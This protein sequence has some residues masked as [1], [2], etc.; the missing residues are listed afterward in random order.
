MR[1][2]LLWMKKF[3]SVLSRALEYLDSRN[4]RNWEN[5][6]DTFSE[7]ELELLMIFQVLRHNQQV[8][9]LAPA[10]Q[11]ILQQRPDLFP[12]LLMKGTWTRVRPELSIEGSVLKL[13]EESVAKNSDLDLPTRE[14]LLE[15][16]RG[17]LGF[18]L[19]LKRKRGSPPNRPESAIL[20]NHAKGAGGGWQP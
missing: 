10:E 5:L 3:Q 1:D 20:E 4:G 7:R 6:N 15:L 12:E 14:T 9:Q 17:R 19:T 2:D 8:E 13:L 16:L 18:R 11:G